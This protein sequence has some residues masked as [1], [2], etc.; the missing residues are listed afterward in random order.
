MPRKRVL[1]FMQ[2]AS[3]LQMVLGVVLF[4]TPTFTQATG[5][6][7]WSATV[8]GVLVAATGAYDEW[9]ESH[10]RAHTVALPS[11]LT[12]VVGLWLVVFP[13]FASPGPVYTV[14]T[15]SAGALLVLLG[16]A[17]LTASTRFDAS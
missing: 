15:A 13:L 17:S 8:L 3:W 12:M 4:V 9:A 1:A 6:A 11:M 2:L 10:A 14:L 5:F 16:G 7:Y